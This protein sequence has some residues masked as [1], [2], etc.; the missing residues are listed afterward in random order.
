MS[1]PAA[2][3]WQFLPARLARRLLPRAACALLAA[4][5]ADLMARSCRLE[6]DDEPRT[7]AARGPDARGCAPARHVASGKLPSP[8]RAGSRRN[9]SSRPRA[10]RRELRSSRHGHRAAAAAGRPADRRYISTRGDHRGVQQ[11]YS[12]RAA[13]VPFRVPM[14]LSRACPANRRAHR[15]RMLGRGHRRRRSRRI[16]GSAP[17]RGC[18]RHCDFVRITARGRRSRAMPG[19]LFAPPELQDRTLTGL[20]RRDDEFRPRVDD[21]LFMGRHPFAGRYLGEGD[22]P[23]EQAIRE[24]RFAYGSE[25]DFAAMEQPPG[26]PPLDM[27]SP[28]AAELFTAPSRCRRPGEPAVGGGMDPRARNPGGGAGAR[29]DRD[30]ALAFRRLARMPLVP[31]RGDDRCWCS[32]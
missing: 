3:T 10:R 12:A 26:T 13:E 14:A 6:D 17:R 2:G 8:C 25:H 29:P 27:V 30:C 31:G 28:P 23:I 22:M 7:V 20:I 4:A 21:W 11:L 19:C 32:R 15:R 18:V 24:H 16:L 5:V 1:L 9:L